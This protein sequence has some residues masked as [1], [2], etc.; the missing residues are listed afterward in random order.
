[1]NINNPHRRSS[2]TNHFKRFRS[3]I[4]NVGLHDKHFPASNKKIAK[5][6]EIFKFTELCDKKKYKDTE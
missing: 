3:N 1:M 4:Q 5:S 2:V 6:G